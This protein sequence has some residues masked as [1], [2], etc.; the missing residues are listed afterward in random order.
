MT[1]PAHDKSKPL[2]TAA[3]ARKPEPP[4]SN[5][6]P[7][8][9]SPAAV[10]QI[11][12]GSK[13][14]W[15]LAHAPVIELMDDVVGARAHHDI[16]IIA[17][18]RAQQGPRVQAT[19]AGDPAIKLAQVP[20]Y[21]PGTAM[22]DP[23]SVFK[24]DFVPKHGGLHEGTLEVD[25]LDDPKQHLSI[26]IHAWSREPGAKTRAQTLA[27][28]AQARTDASNREATAAARADAEKRIAREDNEA[29]N[30]HHAGNLR[31]LDRKREDIQAKMM[32]LSGKRANGITFAS[33]NI[34]VFKRQVPRPEQPSLLGQ[35]AWGALDMVTGGVARSVSG[36][37]KAPLE[38]ALT[39]TRIEQDPELLQYGVGPTTTIV[40]A[41][42][43]LVG[44]IVEGVR[45]GVKAGGGAVKEWVK[46]AL[47]ADPGPENVEGNNSTNAKDV[48][49]SA[50]TD[51]V[52][53]EEHQNAATTARF[54]HDS[55]LDTLDVAP[56]A[57][58][59][60]MD[61]MREG[62][63]AAFSNAIEAQRAE[64]FRN[65]LRYLTQTSVGSSTKRK[66]ED[67]TDVTDIDRATALKGEGSAKTF[68][69]IVD[70]RVTIDEGNPQAPAIP[71]SAMIRGVAKEVGDTLAK[72]PLLGARV[73]VRAVAEPSPRTPDSRLSIS[74]DE[75]G[76]LAF[77]DRVAGGETAP[78]RWLSRKAGIVPGS[79]AGQREGARVLI[80]DEVMAEPL[81]G[82]LK[83]D[84]AT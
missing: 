79:E 14:G 17:L 2:P 18:D 54:V 25:I 48:F 4:G 28:E 13:S 29:T 41:S 67:G 69:G 63:Q 81:F 60:V 42:A 65:W 76:N 39:T 5:A 20:M 10:D 11:A 6:P 26:P 68:D 61:T 82:K 56:Q 40:P 45:G 33:G 70:V 8:R 30:H 44:F 32:D 78:S 36:F 53:G 23:A 15:Q 84:S 57:A 38:R 43:T 75:A 83:T 35:L 51:A 16:S 9:T 19:V 1:E 71:K 72:K 46:S 55:L 3:A 34:G 52:T 77:E 50:Q 22:F 7:D 31:V 12:A 47:S 74:R 27:A 24:I 37:L 58:F 62:L 59:A 64:T 73:P 21:L 49:I 66:A 80:E